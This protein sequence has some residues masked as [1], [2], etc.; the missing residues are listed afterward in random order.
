MYL[1]KDLI[2]VILSVFILVCAL[3]IILDFNELTVIPV[4]IRESLFPALLS[5]YITLLGFLLSA[6]SI[7]V[8]LSSLGRLPIVFADPRTVRQLFS[9]FNNG[10]LVFSM[11]TI[12]LILSMV[13]KVDVLSEFPCITMPNLLLLG[14]C[15]VSLGRCINMVARIA[16]IASRPSVARSGPSE[17]S[18]LDQDEE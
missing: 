14:L 11:A 4:R 17:L 13:L 1:L 16:S 3:A 2:L 12:V 7:I 10:F 6:F 5:G 9:A 18:S 8:G 15:A